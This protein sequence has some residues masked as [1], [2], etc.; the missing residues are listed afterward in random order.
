MWFGRN[1]IW[2]WLSVPLV[3][4]DP[5]LGSGRGAPEQINIFQGVKT[6]LIACDS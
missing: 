3:L 1:G 6:P 2:K 4:D 5:G